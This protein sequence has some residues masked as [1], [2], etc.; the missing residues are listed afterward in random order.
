MWHLSQASR[1]LDSCDPTSAEFYTLIMRVQHVYVKW[2]MLH[3]TSEVTMHVKVKFIM[4]LLTVFFSQRRHFNFY[5]IIWH[6]C[7]FCDIC[8]HTGN[9]ES[10]QTI[11]MEQADTH[12]FTGRTK[13]VN[14]RII[15]TFRYQVWWDLGISV[16][17]IQ[18]IQNW[19]LSGLCWIWLLLGQ[20]CHLLQLRV[21][22]L[23][24]PNSGSILRTMSDPTLEL[25]PELPI[26]TTLYHSISDPR[27]PP[28]LPDMSSLSYFLFEHCFTL[29]YLLFPALP[30]AMPVCSD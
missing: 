25:D 24:T 19:S 21:T 18:W 27:I 16:A 22:Q 23:R 17:Y 15:L 10:Q 7:G 20:S 30:S 4:T 11:N 6:N 13:Y 28:L 3:D 12:T 29:P 26:G 8:Q 5:H 2:T 1:V 9:L 14:G